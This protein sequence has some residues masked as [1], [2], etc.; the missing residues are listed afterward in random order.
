MRVRGV[1]PRPVPVVIL[2]GF[3]TSAIFTFHEFVAPVIRRL[4]GHPAEH[5]QVVQAR[6]PMRVNSERGRTE[7]LL[8]GLVEVS[9][10]QAATDV[11]QTEHE[12]KIEVGVSSAFNPWLNPLFLDPI[13]FHLSI[14][15]ASLEAQ[16][17]RGAADVSVIIVEL[18]QNVVALVGRTG[19]MQCLKVAAGAT[20]AV[21]IDKRRQVLSVELA[22]GGIHDHNALD[23]IA[24]LANISRPRI[25]H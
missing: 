3:P 12:E 20:A 7:Y 23:G 9:A 18:F 22:G 17:F 21:A 24:Q 1:P 16:H 14:K 4:A 15:M 5:S 6:L 10:R 11:T 2:P 19:L 8:V 25:A 13:R